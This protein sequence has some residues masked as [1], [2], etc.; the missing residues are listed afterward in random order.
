MAVARFGGAGVFLFCAPIHFASP[1]IAEISCRYL[2]SQCGP[3]LSVSNSAAHSKASAN[4]RTPWPQRRLRS[5]IIVH[6]VVIARFTFWEYV[7]T[8]PATG[9]APGSRDFVR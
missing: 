4:R 8:L 9:L 3:S 1:P 6:R 7:T 2:H 5:L